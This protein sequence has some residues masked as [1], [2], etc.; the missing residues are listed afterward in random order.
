MDNQRVGALVVVDGGRPV[1]LLTDRDVALRVLA[2]RRDANSTRVGD[3]AGD[4]PVTLTE[5]VSLPEASS[6]MR[7]L[8]LRR[9]PVVDADGNV[10]GMLT[11]DD[12]VRVLANELESLADVASEQ[13]PPRRPPLQE[14][15]RSAEHYAKEVVTVA[16]ET[17]AGDVAQRMRSESVGSVVVV[18]ES[19]APIGIITD[20][21]LARRV[22]AKG[23]DPAQTTAASIMSDQLLTVDASERLQQVA[24]MMSD[25]GVR[26]IPV[27]HERRLVGI[28]T[29]DDVL[30]ALGRELH[31]LGEAA[32]A[33]IRRER[34]SA[35]TEE[36]R[37]EVEHAVEALGEW[38]EQLG[39]EAR[40][41]L[42]RRL[43]ALRG[44][45]GGPD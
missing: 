38:L 4:P 10:V 42:R 16:G 31:D 24:R 2:D 1:G 44:R 8:G 27:L 18:N 41:A 30:V 15:L 19:G 40:A 5:D 9:M 14:A 12:L 25:H 17:C 21:D 35:R 43:D 36:A 11:V 23:T 45:L 7:R 34:L 13:V 20:R 28:V 33:G 32:R 39:D 37:R 3:L 6:R 22:V 26:R 29:Y